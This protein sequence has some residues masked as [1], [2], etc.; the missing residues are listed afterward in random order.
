M[1]E[2]SMGTGNIQL[3][4]DNS[5]QESNKRDENSIALSVLIDT[6]KATQIKGRLLMCGHRFSTNA[7]IQKMRDPL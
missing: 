5:F 6:L 2:T 7:V 4:I 3:S 1:R